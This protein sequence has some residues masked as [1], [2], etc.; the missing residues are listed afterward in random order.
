MAAVSSYSDQTGAITLGPKDSLQAA[1]VK[2]CAGLINNGDPQQISGTD[3][4]TPLQGF[5]KS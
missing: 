4:L 2:G 1:D 5:T 3:T